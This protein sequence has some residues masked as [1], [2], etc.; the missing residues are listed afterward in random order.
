MC[1]RDRYQR[2][3]RGLHRVKMSSNASLTGFRQKLVTCIEDLR[4]RREELNQSIRQDEMEKVTI[5]NKLPS[6]SMHLSRS[7]DKIS[8]LDKSQKEIEQAIS[9]ITECNRRIQDAKERYKLVVDRE[10]KYHAD[11]AAKGL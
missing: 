3:V 7:Q 2:R 4:N 11:R 10:R 6:L 1:I 9:E 8:R 5:E